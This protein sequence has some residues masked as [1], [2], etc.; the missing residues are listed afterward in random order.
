MRALFGFR[1]SGIGNISAEHTPGRIPRAAS[2]IDATFNAQFC[3]NELNAKNNETNQGRA[4][5]SN[6]MFP[7]D[8]PKQTAIY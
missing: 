6:T 4:V 2:M 7:T 1:A 8:T 5:V 3:L